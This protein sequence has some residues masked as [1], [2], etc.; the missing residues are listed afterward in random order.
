MPAYL[1]FFIT[2]GTHAA[3]AL[4]GRLAIQW[5]LVK[6]K[7]RL[8]ELTST[9]GRCYLP[10]KARAIKHCV[11]GLT[12]LLEVTR[13]QQ[14]HRSNTWTHNRAL[15]NFRSRL[16]QDGSWTAGWPVFPQCPDPALAMVFL[17]Q[18]TP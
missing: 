13:T 17:Y 12:T 15:K 14:Q 2:Q 7:Q 3:Q 6:N 16:E 11:S 10:H 8:L 1:Q 18:L 5:T 4:V 9:Q